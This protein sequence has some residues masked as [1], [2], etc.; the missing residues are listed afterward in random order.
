[1]KTACFATFSIRTIRIY[2]I[3]I[4]LFK[5]SMIMEGVNGNTEPY[6]KEAKID[7]LCETYVV[8]IVTID[9]RHREHNT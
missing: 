1:M 3:L 6:L 5:F 2:S 9:T 8:T 4:T 7:G